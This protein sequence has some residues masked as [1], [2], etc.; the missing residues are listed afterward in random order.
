M[1]ICSVTIRLVVDPIALIN[2]A[3]SVVKFAAT[4]CL[5]VA[6]EALVATAIEPLLLALAVTDTIEPFTFVNGT[7]VQVDRWTKF[8]DV[9]LEAV[10]LK[11]RSL[12]TICSEGR[13]VVL[14][15][16]SVRDA[17]HVWAASNHLTSGA[18]VLVGAQGRSHGILVDPVH[19]ILRAVTLSC[20]IG[21][22][23]GTVSHSLLF[24]T[25]I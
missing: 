8:S 5:S 22:K 10:C 24:S 20:A 25:I 18:V 7:T 11:G 3:I 15:A 14:I 23:P 13:L 9:F 12:G 1:R 2:I 17:L 16:V 21:K 19:G 4:I 6:P